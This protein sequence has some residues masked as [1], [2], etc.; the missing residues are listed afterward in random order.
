MATAVLEEARQWPGVDVRVIPAMPAA[1]AVASRV[2]APLGHAYAVI[3]AASFRV[4]RRS[5]TKTVPANF[6]AG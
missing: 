6:R 5:G 2:G 1:Q 3:A 4:S